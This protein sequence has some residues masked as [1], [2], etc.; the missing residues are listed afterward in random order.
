MPLSPVSDCELQTSSEMANIEIDAITDA[1]RRARV[2][3][4]LPD[5]KAMLEL[6]DDLF[7]RALEL[8]KLG[9]KPAD[10]MHV[11]AAKAMGADAFLSCNDRLVRLARRRRDEL[12]VL[13]ANP[14]DWLR[15]MRHD[16]DA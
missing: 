7:T 4:L 3:L 15:E 14:L 1:A 8:E 5:R 13:V 11:A 2:Q 9:F 6:T 16:D 12:K 10:A